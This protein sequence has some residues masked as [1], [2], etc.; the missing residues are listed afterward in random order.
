MDT[1]IGTAACESGMCAEIIVLKSLGIEI[2]IMKAA[3]LLTEHW[4]E[5][6]L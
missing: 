6:P 5:K 1:E 2:W 3:S 4:K